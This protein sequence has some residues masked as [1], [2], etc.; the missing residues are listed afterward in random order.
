MIGI[1]VLYGFG[2]IVAVLLF[3]Y[4]VFALICAEEF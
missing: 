4:L 2:A 1:D 3:A